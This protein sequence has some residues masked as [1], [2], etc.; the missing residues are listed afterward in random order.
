MKGIIAGDVGGTKTSLALFSPEQGPF[1]PLARK[2]YSSPSY[3]S[4]DAMLSDFLQETGAQADL[5]VFGVAGPVEGTAARIT[6]LSWTIDAGQ[7]SEKLGIRRIR[8]LNDLEAAASGVPVLRPQDLHVINQ[9]K[10]EE[11]GTIA[12][13]APGTGLGESFLTWDGRRY[14]AHAS[15]G[16]HADFAPGN[17][18]EIQLLEYLL[19]RWDHVSYERICSGSGLPNVYSFLRDRVLLQEPGWLKAG[20]ETA[21]DRTALIIGAALDESRSCD[22]CREC[23]RMFITVLGAEAGN[24]AL[25]LLPRGG[26]YIGGGI[27]PRIKDAFSPYGF[28]DAFLR[29]GRLSRILTGMPI[30]II[31]NTDAGLIG[32]ACFG[33][34]ILTAERGD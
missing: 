16:G 15:E 8:L 2:S 24:M 29:K 6:N 19:D 18:R 26:I 23:L 30:R 22:L 34:N 5:A 12:V 10:P 25:K 20:M 27:P 21:E 13:I 17:R 32:S 11:H 4:F 1:E 14:A 28:M 33:L 3:G 9:G 31:L 7:L